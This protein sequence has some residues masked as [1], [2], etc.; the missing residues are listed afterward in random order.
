MHLPSAIAENDNTAEPKG[1][2]QNEIQERVSFSNQPL[3]KNSSTEV[4]ENCN[5]T[6]C[7]DTK[8][9]HTSPQQVSS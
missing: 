8:V 1:V 3:Q 4:T 2:N 9:P 6:K 7:V 5:D